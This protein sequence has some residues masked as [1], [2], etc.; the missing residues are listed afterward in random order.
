MGY[1]SDAKDSVRLALETAYGVYQRPVTVT[2]V[3]EVGQERLPYAARTEFRPSSHPAR[4]GSGG[5]SVFDFWDRVKRWLDV[6][7]VEGD[8]FRE[9]E[10]NR[11]VYTPI[12]SETSP[13]LDRFTE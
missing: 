2:E 4:R 11:W 1:R 5:W 10:G 9:R 7:T 6:I 13:E 3:R 12:Y 8:A